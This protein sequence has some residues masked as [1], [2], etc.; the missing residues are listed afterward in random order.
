MASSDDAPLGRPSVSADLVVVDPALLEEPDLEPGEQVGEFV[1]GGKLGEGGFGAVFAA[2]HPVIGKQ[3][4]IKVLNRRYSSDPGMVSRFVAEARAVNQIRHRHIIDIFSFGQLPDGRQYYVM[5]L[6]AGKTLHAY[7]RERRRLSLAEALP[8]LRAIARA[9]DAAHAKGIAH[10][11]LKPDNVFIALDDDGTIYPKLLDF[12]LAKLIGDDRP[13][14][15]TRTGAPMGTPHYMSPEQ[16]RGRKMDTRTD[17]YSFGVVTYQ[18]LTGKVPFDGADFM[19][20]VC[21]Q[22][23]E[24]PVPAS[25][26]VP[27]LPASVDR[28]IAWMMKK[29]ASRRPHNLMAALRA[30]EEAAAE[31]GVALPPSSAR[32]SEGVPEHEEEDV[33]EV[34]ETPSPSLAPTRPALA[35]RKAAPEPEPS[36][37]ANGVVTA[38]L[39]RRRFPLRQAAA[40]VLLVGMST[41]AYLPSSTAPAG[42][43]IGVTSAPATTPA[44]APMLTPIQAPAPERAS[45]PTVAPAPVRVTSARS[46]APTRQTGRARRL[47][48]SFTATPTPASEPNRAADA[49]QDP[50]A[51]KERLED[52]GD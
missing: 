22:L 20:I 30:L 24:Q 52:F 3:V 37:D 28:C 32:A 36:S 15:K 35:P 26:I 48:S 7:L 39:A 10:R 27:D 17:I 1:V 9:L 33:E 34:E 46:A 23:R 16:C 47:A 4:A 38:P 45:V 42:A 43:R 18:L 40:L 6:L 31:V 13:A 25:Q 21:K 41:V 19:D 2:A 8:I 50:D 29:E 51:A 11:D 12:G 5:E 14:H 49:T 44:A